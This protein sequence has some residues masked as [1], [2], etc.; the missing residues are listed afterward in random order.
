MLLAALSEGEC[1][2][3]SDRL[4]HQSRRLE[5]VYNRRYSHT[6]CFTQIRDLHGLADLHRFTVQVVVGTAL[7]RDNAA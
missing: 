6:L 2:N 1:W 5:A 7:G 3:N 4:E